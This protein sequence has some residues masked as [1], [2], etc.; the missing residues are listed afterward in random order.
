MTHLPYGVGQNR[1]N[2]QTNSWNQIKW[3]L[4]GAFVLITGGML[5]YEYSVR[6]P[7][8]KCEASGHW[9][10]DKDRKC[11]T[12]VYLPDWTGRKPDGKAASDHKLLW[13]DAS[14]PTRT[15]AAPKPDD[16]AQPTPSKP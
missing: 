16:S 2:R 5:A 6:A 7:R 4:I 1:P 8:A 15:A 9:W 12:V 3:M 10:S 14:D 11:A 13:P